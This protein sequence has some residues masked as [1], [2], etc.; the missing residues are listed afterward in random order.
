VAPNPT[1]GRMHVRL[2]QAGE[3]SII[4]FDHMG[5]AVHQQQVLP[6]DGTAI[7]LDLSGM[8]QGIYTLR[9]ANKETFSTRNIILR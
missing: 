5:R 3:Y 6:T 4:I 8:R 2:P 1:E 7:S 9:L